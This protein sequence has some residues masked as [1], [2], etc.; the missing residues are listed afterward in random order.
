[1]STGGADYDGRKV[2]EARKLVDAALG[3]YPELAND[4]S[5]TSW[6]GSSAASTCSRPRRTYKMAEFYKR[7]GHPGSAYFYY[8]IVRRRYPNTKF[9]ELAAR[10]H[11]LSISSWSKRRT[12]QTKRATR[13]RR[14]RPS[15]EQAPPPRVLPPGL[16]R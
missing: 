9:A 7:T 8:E 2:A 4:R 11:E 5:R 13:R 3:N 6:S 12:A 15:P 10:A 14:R 1:M 16:E